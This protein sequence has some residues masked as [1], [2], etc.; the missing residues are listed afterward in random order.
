MLELKPCP[1]CGKEAKMYTNNKIATFLYGHSYSVRCTNELCYCF[2]VSN[3]TET[4]EA[5]I[6]AW[7]KRAGKEETK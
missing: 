4:K 1:F 7:N 6:A 3:P 5:A 2:V